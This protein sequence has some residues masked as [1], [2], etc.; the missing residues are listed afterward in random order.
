MINKFK[1]TLQTAVNTAMGKPTIVQ[2]Y[3]ELTSNA[4][5]ALLIRYNTVQGKRKEKNEIMKS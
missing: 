5:G 4:L 2:L 1:R 3:E